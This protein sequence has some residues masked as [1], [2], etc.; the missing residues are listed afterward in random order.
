MT[1]NEPRDLAYW[2]PEISDCDIEIHSID[3][4]E[5]GCTHPNAGDE[6]S[7][8]NGLDGCYG[9]GATPQAAYAAMLVELSKWQLAEQ[10]HREDAQRDDD[11][12]FM[13]ACGDDASHS[14]RED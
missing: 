3:P 6:A 9:Y 5:Y 10:D 4:D 1:T 11:H 7:G 8:H 12:E 13:Y 14:R 2:V